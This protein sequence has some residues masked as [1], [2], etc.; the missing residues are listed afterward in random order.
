MLKKELKRDNEVCYM[1]IF[2]IY[3][4]FYS[5]LINIVYFSSK[6]LRSIEN[7]IFEKIMLTNFVG[8]LLAIGSYFTIKNID[9]FELLNTFVSKGYIIYLLTWLTLF[10]VYI[11]VISIKDGKDK[12]SEVN[13]II[14]LFGI[15]YLIFLIIIIIK[16]L[17]YHNINGA[18][19]SYGPS[20]NVMYIV[21]IVYITVWLIRL[22]TNIKRIRDKKYLPIFAFMGLGLVVM[23]IQK[24]HPELLLMTSMETFIVFLMYHTIENPDMQIIE[25]VHRAKEI[26]DNANEEKSMFLYNMTNEIRGITKDIDYSAD[27]ILEEVD[28]KKVD[29]LNI[30]NSAREIKNNTAKFTTMTNEILDIS[31]MDSNIKI[32]NDKYNVKIII[33]ELVQIYKKKAEDKGISFRTNI[34]S[35]IPPYLYGD[36]MGLKKALSIILDNSVKYTSSGFIDFDV[37]TIIK[38]DIAR[39]VIT[40]E[41]SGSG[42]KAED[43]NKIF[44]KKVNDNERLNIK[45]NL[46]NAKRL[47]ILMG[48]TIIPSSVYGRGTTIKVVLDQKIADIDDALDKYESV[49]DKK[50]ILLVDD[51]VS[52]GKIFTKMLKD[53]NIELSIVTS[54]KECLDKIRNKDKYDLILLDEDM[55]PLDGITVM[56]KLKE[57]RTFNTKTILLTKNNDYEYNDDYLEYGFDGYLLKPIDKDK[58]FELIDKYLK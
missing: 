9:R 54:G 43:L 2:T 33:K 41:D 58:L 48:G 35:D 25:E 38:R 8:V 56:R 17:Y 24:Q 10:S 18:I 37:N 5:L 12:K 21:S 15:L 39:L 32:Y 34:A 23:I 27:N 40:V 44:N 36:S 46:Y 49:Y 57:I 19:Y 22:S 30:G 47:V 6:R 55:E 53:T 20:A 7:K 16:P 51:N 26:S 3:S 50:S 45:Y 4:L 1:N 52:S 13:K 29:V 42:I 31:Q 14:N 28:N 11:F